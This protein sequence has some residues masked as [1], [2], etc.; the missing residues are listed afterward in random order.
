MRGL[1]RA[2]FDNPRRVSRRVALSGF[3][4]DVGGVGGVGGVRAKRRD[5]GSEPKN[6][7]ER[8]KVSK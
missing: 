2:R 6:F 8:V 7:E 3:G 1:T 5:G 4:E